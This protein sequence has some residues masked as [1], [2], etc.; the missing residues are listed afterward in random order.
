MRSVPLARPLAALALALAL[1]A[2]GR[3]P[4]DSGPLAVTVNSVNQSDIQ[5]PGVVQ[6][7]ENISNDSGNPWGEF[8]R[9]A[10]EECG[11]D[12]VA[13]E[14]LG[15]SVALDT[16]GGA[17]VVSRFEDVVSGMAAAHFSSTSHSDPAAVSA[18]V[19]SIATP[20]GAGPIP[21]VP[22]GT[23]AALAPLHD[24]LVGGDFHVG[25]RAETSL[26]AGD[27]FTMDVRVDFAA[28]AHCD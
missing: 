24:R 23:R 21:L 22:S 2:C 5:V 3:G 27:A 15:A 20:A 4:V 7:D 13:F 11:A 12:P 9:R 16:S 6:K 8:V 18:D 28:R 17:G 19:G 26:G 14:I 25:F 1:T 10:R